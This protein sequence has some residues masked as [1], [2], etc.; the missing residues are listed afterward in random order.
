MTNL[1]RKKIIEKF[2]NRKKNL[3]I[4]NQEKSC[5]QQFLLAVTQ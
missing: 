3:N 4:L 2:E 1:E 5:P